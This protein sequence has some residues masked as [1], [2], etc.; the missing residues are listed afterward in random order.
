MDDRSGCLDTAGAACRR[1]CRPRPR[2][3]RGRAGRRSTT[4]AGRDAP[5]RP[6]AQR[7]RTHRAIRPAGTRRG[8]SRRVA[9]DCAATWPLPGFRCYRPLSGRPVLPVLWKLPEL[10]TPC[11]HKL[12]GNHRTVSTSS[13]SL[14]P[15]SV[16][17]PERQ[18]SRR[19]RRNVRRALMRFG[20]PF[21]GR[22]LQ[23]LRAHTQTTHEGQTARNQTF[24]GVLRQTGFGSLC[25]N[26]GMS[27]KPAVLKRMTSMAQGRSK[28]MPSQVGSFPVSKGLASCG[29]RRSSGKAGA[30]GA[31]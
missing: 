24:R 29:P 26:G 20:G 16:H 6:H 18:G 10:W 12:L 2:R 17:F 8:W 21:Y 28:R 31:A 1:V 19:F 13:H 4:P 15:P 5:P 25:A 9:A 11:A 3:V 22:R 14:L 27:L 30:A 7:R 23:L